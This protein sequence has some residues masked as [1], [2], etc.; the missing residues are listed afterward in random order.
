MEP[1]KQLAVHYMCPFSQRVLFV[2]ALKNLDVDIVEVDL[3]N[4]SEWFRD[5][6]PSI[7]APALKIIHGEKVIRLAQSHD[8][9]IYFNSFPG[10]NL[11]PMLGD[12]PDPTAKSEIDDFIKTKICKAGSY[13]YSVIY[14]GPNE[15]ALKEFKKFI[16][17]L[18]ELMENG[19]FLMEKQVGFREV[20]MADVMLYP[21]VERYVALEEHTRGALDNT[22]GLHKWFERMNEFS[23]IQKYKVPLHRHKKLYQI[24]TGPGD[25]QPFTLPITLYD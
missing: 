19:Q 1:F 17:F 25:Y 15:E 7:E 18:E 2:A 22:P 24:R 13:L 9:S 12:H 16:S 11:Y 20:S 6:N 3:M 8:I 14:Y 23:W 10:Q 21:F 5:L 4:P